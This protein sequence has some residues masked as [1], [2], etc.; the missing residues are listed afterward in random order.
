MGMEQAWLL[1]AIP[2]AVFVVVALFHR[3]LPRQGDWVAIFGM[4]AVTVLSVFVIVDF[5]GAFSGGEFIA[6]TEGAS[7][8]AWSYEWVNIGDGFFTI[9]ISTFVDAITI[10]MI[11][12]VSIV[13]LLVM[14]YSVGYMRGEAR[15]GWYFALLSFF[16]AAMLTLV[17]S[18]NLLMLYLAWEAVGLGSYL[19]IG[20]WWERQSAAEAAKKAFITTR[21]GDVGLLTGI[22]LLW[23]ATGS[24]DIQTIIERAG[25]IDET[26]LTVTML[27][28]LAGAIGKSAQFP[29]H[30]WLPD[31]ME[32]PTPVSA[33]IH[34][35][36]M[37]V[38]GVY[39][40]ARL[41]PVFDHVL[42]ARDVVLYIGLITTVMAAGM[43]LVSNDIKRV[44]AY[45]TM[46]QIGFMFVALGVGSVTAAM[47]HLLTHAFFKSLLFLGAGSVI[48]STEQQEVERLGGLRSKMPITAG[49]FM[50]GGLALAGIVP[51]AGFWSKDEILLATQGEAHVIV[52][53]ILAATAML[54]AIYTTR[55]IMLTFVSEPRD[56]H[57]HEH[58]HESPPVMIIPLVML[59]T[60][61][62]VAGFVAFERIGEA[63]GFT[64]GIGALV[65][66]GARGHGFE[67]DQ[68]LALGATVS[69]LAGVAIGIFYWHGRAERAERAR[70]WA[71][72]LHALLVNRFY[73]DHLYQGVI[74]RAV[75]GLSAIVLW[76]DRFVINESGIDGGAQSIGYAGLRLKFLQTGRIPNYALAMAVGVVAIALVAFGTR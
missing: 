26:Y 65:F 11:T 47:F 15:Y 2:A 44:L 20:F 60:L 4:A 29:L 55:L 34:A 75:M 37:V 57:V 62:V 8:N 22:I 43:A 18:G 35:A 64:G 46:S 33:L 67:F 14:V 1:P 63:L 16:S 19:L 61:S 9:D 68:T 45:S 30:V 42:I 31:A 52:F 13:T 12:V 71:P 41:M 23:R 28:I 74:D 48:H 38:A 51:L 39:L 27:F 69:A 5:Q 6:G 70:S 66:T 32:G 36:T 17:T 58:A 24:F 49:T 59:A 7:K 76:F 50:I 56:R 3:L 40:V 54:T 72:E 53:G 25:T 21:I 10:V 73:I